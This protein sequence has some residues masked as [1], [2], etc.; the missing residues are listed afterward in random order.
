MLELD[1]QRL[2]LAQVVAVAHGQETVTLTPSSR[3]RVLQSRK[4]V[5]Q[6][7]AQG[8]TVYGVNTGFGK[9]SDV[10]IGPSELR[11]LQTNLVRSHSCGVGKPL[12]QA[13]TRAMLLLRANVL[14]A[15]FSGARAAVI[16][17]LLA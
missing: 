1:G 11:N 16:D 5:E 17:T 14:A 12:S 9:L 15:G 7:I 13:E 3:E 2:S 4:V 8:R 6:I 10:R